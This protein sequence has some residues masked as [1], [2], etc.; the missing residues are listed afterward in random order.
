MLLQM[1]LFSSFL[2]SLIL[3]KVKFE[4]N[5]SPFPFGKIISLYFFWL[6][7]G[8]T[9]Q[10]LGHEPGTNMMKVKCS[11]L[12]KAMA[13]HSSTLAWKIPW[14]EEPGGLQSMGLHH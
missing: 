11:G 1:A 3:L 5:S 12:E 14:A 2:M 6:V 7:V 10:R 4:R 9:C 8:G 13:P